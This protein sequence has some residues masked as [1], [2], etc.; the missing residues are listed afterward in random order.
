MKKW[1]LMILVMI[2]TGCGVKEEPVVEVEEVI[3]E[4]PERKHEGYVV[5]GRYY[6]SDR[7]LITSDGNGWEYQTDEVSETVP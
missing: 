5:A 4:V 3:V 6:P 7:L 2:L 1:A